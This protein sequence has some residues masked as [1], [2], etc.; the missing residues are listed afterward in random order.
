MT[1]AISE[2]SS[3]NAIC[4]DTHPPEDSRIGRY[5]QHMLESGME[6]FRLNFNF[7]SPEASGSPV[8]MRGE[9]CARIDLFDQFNAHEGI[10]KRICNT[11]YLLG[12]A[13]VR[14][15][16]GELINLG[17]DARRSTVIHCHDPILLPLAA[18]LAKA[19]RSWRLVYDRHELYEDSHTDSGVNVATALE[20]IARKHIS[21]VVVVSDE[22]ID[23]TRRR[24]PGAEVVSVPNY[25]SIKD[26]DENIIEDK[27]NSLDDDT[28]AVISYI[29]S[30]DNSFDRDIDLMLRIGAEAAA[31][32]KARFLIGGRANDAGIEQRMRDL[33]RKFPDDFSFQGYV[34]RKRTVEL[35]AASHIGL[36]LM[37][38]ETCYWV[39]C[40]PNKVFEYLICGTVPVIRADVDRADEISQSALLFDRNAGADEIV[41][42]VMSLISDRER[43]RSMMRRAREQSRNFTFESVAGRYT[44]IYRA[45][46]K[47]AKE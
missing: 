39:K 21:G 23:V 33:S 7:Y 45:V 17:L 15:A 36:Y 26:Y 44:E 29:G 25:P 5:L 2:L 4:L 35:T 6:T 31:S 47:G 14:L 9:K 37:K 16:E 10:L 12:S 32:G 41:D 40:S 19:H 38:P 27:I 3:W 20:K 8:S 43:L 1:K 18:N 22:H 34:P 46:M 30:L 11:R 42:E 24:F 13:L 28:K